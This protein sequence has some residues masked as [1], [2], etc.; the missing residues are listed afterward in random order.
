MTENFLSTKFIGTMVVIILA[1]ALVFVGKLEAQT[2]LEMAVA[3]VGIYS[4]ANVAQKFIPED[5]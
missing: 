4:A 1:Y 3:G 2:W 5:K